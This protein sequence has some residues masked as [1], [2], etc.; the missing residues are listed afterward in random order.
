MDFS[1]R[2]LGRSRICFQKTV[3]LTSNFEATKHR[4]II[5]MIR[6]ILLLILILFVAWILSPFLRTKDSNKTKDT[7]ERILDSDRSKFRQQNTVLIISAVI[8]FALIVWLLP[9]FGINFLGLLQK[10]IPI[11]SS[12]RGILP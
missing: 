8:L 7:V 11:M 2:L 12:L 6:L 10:I 3:N 9:K 4:E 5:F 1:D